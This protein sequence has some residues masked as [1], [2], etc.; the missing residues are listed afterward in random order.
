MFVSLLLMINC[1][2]S[3]IVF[4]YP[5]HECYCFKI[6]NFLGTEKCLPIYFAVLE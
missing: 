4:L 3:G 1:L 2:Q 5:A 6:S